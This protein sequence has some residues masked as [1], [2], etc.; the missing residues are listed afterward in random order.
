VALRQHLYGL[1]GRLLRMVAV[2]D[3]L[4]LDVLLGSM[5]L[6][7]RS[8]VRD[9]LPREVRRRGG[10]CSSDVETLS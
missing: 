9:L 8:L 4:P 10:G 1:S 2:E 3:G 6:E 7:L 5:S